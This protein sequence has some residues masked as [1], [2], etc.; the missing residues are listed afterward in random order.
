MIAIVIEED[1]PSIHLTTVQLARAVQVPHFVVG[2]LTLLTIDLQSNALAKSM[3]QPITTQRLAQL[4][5]EEVIHQGN[6][7]IP[8]RL[9]QEALYHQERV[10]R[11][12]HPHL[13]LPLGSLAG[14]V[15]P[16][17]V[18]IVI[19][20]LFLAVTTVQDHLGLPEDGR[21]TLA[22]AVMAVMVDAMPIH[23]DPKLSNMLTCTNYSKRISF[24]HADIYFFCNIHDLVCFL[25]SAF[26]CRV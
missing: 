18:I 16:L 7:H 20:L 5:E 17:I 13:D 2:L 14:L 3:I 6:T 11:G 22:V 23:H 24:P 12:L 10:L 15:Y 26:Y 4:T 9:E 8:H 21:L 1:P 25:L 19:L